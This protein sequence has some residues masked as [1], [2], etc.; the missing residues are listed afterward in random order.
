MLF[1]LGA[2]IIFS[3]FWIGVA[4]LILV[5]TVFVTG[6]IGICI[7]G[8]GVASFVAARWVYRM[9]PASMRESVVLEPT[10]KGPNGSSR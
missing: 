6:G 10:S 8:W 2:A 7:W 5:S 4:L 3:L 9:L 1:A